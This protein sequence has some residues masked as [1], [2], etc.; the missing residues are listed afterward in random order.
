MAQARTEV[1]REP[2]REG[3]KARLVGWRFEHRARRA[4]R[5][6][7]RKMLAERDIAR[8]TGARI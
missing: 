4:E 3:L 8:A 2:F 6:A 1:Y 7:V 5:R